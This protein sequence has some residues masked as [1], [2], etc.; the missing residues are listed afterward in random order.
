MIST[1][2]SIKKNIKGK[3]KV[4]GLSIVDDAE[5]GGLEARG[6]FLSC[7]VRPPLT[8]TIDMSR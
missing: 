4:T 6:T 1:Q 5:D 2:F 3:Q 8:G 7:I